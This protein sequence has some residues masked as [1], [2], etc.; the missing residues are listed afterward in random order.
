MSEELKRQFSIRDAYAF[1][2]AHGLEAE[3][4][5]IRD[6]VIE[7]DATYTTSLRKGYS[8]ELFEKRGLFEEFKACGC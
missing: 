7:W 3:A 4:N 8:V 5:A 6:M 2:T 1:A